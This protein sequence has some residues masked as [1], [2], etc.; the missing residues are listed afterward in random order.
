MYDISIKGN[1]IHLPGEIIRSH[2]NSAS[3][4]F[5]N[6]NSGSKML[7]ISPATDQHV[8]RN[9]SSVQQ[10]ILKLKNASGDRTIAI[11]DLILDH[12]L[13]ASASYEAQWDAKFHILKIQ[14]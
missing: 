2:F 4:V 14:L 10:Y 1:H 7:W 12:D 5:I 8:M 11:H 9:F 6:Y 13:E 3:S